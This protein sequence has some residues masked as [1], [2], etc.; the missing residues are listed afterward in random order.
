MTLFLDSADL[1]DARIA[2]AYGFVRGATTNPSLM[3]KAGHTD[4]RS[5]LVSLCQLLPGTVFHQ[6]TGH[7]V[8]ELVA[9][10]AAY[11]GLA[12]NLGL[13]IPCTLPGLQFTAQ[14]AS[15]WVI[16]VTAVFTPSQGYLASQAGARYV[17]P[18]VNR[19]TRFTGDGP[20]LVSLL[21]ETLK[22]SSCEILAAGIKSPAEAVDCLRAGAQ[23]IS[24]PLAVIQA[25]CESALTQQALTDFDSAATQL[26][27]YPYG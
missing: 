2:G 6:L 1:N 12:P 21:V 26:K 23:H 9:Q 4:V 25:M 7:T 10:A 11:R 27:G 18:F 20:H 15:E 13:K 8:E 24:A 16:A 19:A 22:N 17:I 14:A 3:L 5:A